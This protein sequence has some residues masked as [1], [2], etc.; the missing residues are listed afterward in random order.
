MAYGRK[1]GM[2]SYECRE[3]I[4][5]GARVFEIDQA[6]GIANTWIR[7]G[8]DGR[9]EIQTQN[10]RQELGVE[11][12]LYCGGRFSYTFNST[13]IVKEGEE[14]VEEEEVDVQPQ[15]LLK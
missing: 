8:E 12:Q 6:S 15:V 7:G 1:T 4:Q 10:S 3:S 9:K 14:E 13:D 11:S 5:L 2:G